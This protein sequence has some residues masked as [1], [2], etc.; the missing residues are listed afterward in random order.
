MHSTKAA[1]QRFA[2]FLDWLTW[3][4]IALIASAGAIFVGIVVYVLLPRQ[5]SAATSLLLR[6]VQNPV[7]G[8]GLLAI[9]GLSSGAPSLERMEQILRSRR[10]RDI[11][12]QKYELESRL[13][14]THQEALQYLGD[15][16][17]IRTIGAGGLSLRGGVGLV[18]EVACS[19]PSR[20][21]VWTGRTEPFT[22]DEAKQIC[23]QLANDYVVTL[24]D[25]LTTANVKSARD[26]KLFIEERLTEVQAGIGETEDRLQEL[27]TQYLLMEPDSK[28]KELIGAA[29]DANMEHAR[30]ARQAQE[31]A[32]S[33]SMSRSRLQRE[34]AERISQEITQRNPIIVSL[35]QRLAGLRADLATNMGEGKSSQHPDVVV[36]QSAI[37]DVE[38]QLEAVTRDVLQQVTRRPNPL[39]DTLL[40]D[41]TRLEVQLAG[42][43]ARQEKLSQQM[44]EAEDAL[45]ELPPVAREYVHM[46]R[47]RQIQTET[48]TALAR[49]LETAN[50]EEQ[51]ESSASFQVLDEAVPPERKSGPST[52]K[53]TARTF[54]AIVVLL[55]LGWAYRHGMFTEYQG[56]AQ[57]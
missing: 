29:Q 21:G 5:Y 2:A 39:H 30:T 22:T 32:N 47:K 13:G 45:R 48:L 25:Y 3:Q 37:S 8:L 38:R 9:P 28:A 16:T 1:T 10:V 17:T 53:N 24:D 27:Q 23:A 33:L 52:V 50:I 51:R 44:D 55:A 7:S 20:F 40:Q 4:R 6:E 26:T 19:G 56:E 42:I 34:D 12:V 36:L 35:E 54:V 49:Q 15:A 11:L 43:R 41:V 31:L 14:L 46:N 18:T 57:S